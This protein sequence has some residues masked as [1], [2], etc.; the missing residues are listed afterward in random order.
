MYIEKVGW[1]GDST[2]KAR[3]HI[4]MA[5]YV[6]QLRTSTMAGRQVEP[7]TWWRGLETLLAPSPH[8]NSGEDDLIPSDRL[9]YCRTT[10]LQYLQAYAMP[11]FF[12]TS[13]LGRLLCR[14]LGL[15]LHLSSLEDSRNP[16]FLLHPSEDSFVDT[17]NSFSYPS[18]V[19]P[20]KSPSAP[21]KSL[22]P[23]S[24][25]FCSENLSK[26]CSRM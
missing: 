19:R 20:A 18:L 16:V 15:L 3:Q 1:K 24:Y 12:F 13:P 7:S 6:Q 9:Q 2:D 21:T 4:V 11:S 23:S 14:H 17:Q 26:T 8:G 22:N 10:V 5:R 25:S